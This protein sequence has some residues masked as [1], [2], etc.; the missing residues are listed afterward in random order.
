MHP[1]DVSSVCP[2]MVQRSDILAF[3]AATGTYL[4]IVIAQLLVHWLLTSIKMPLIGNLEDPCES[5]LCAFPVAVHVPAF[6]FWQQAAIYDAIVCMFS[7]W[8]HAAVKR[9]SHQGWC[10]D[11]LYFANISLC[12]FDEAATGYHL[13]GKFLEPHSDDS[14]DRLAGNLQKQ[15]AGSIQRSFSSQMLFVG[16]D[17]FDSYSVCKAQARMHRNAN[18]GLRPKCNN[19]ARSLASPLKQFLEE[20]TA[21]RFC[22]NVHVHVLMKELQGGMSTLSSASLLSRDD[23]VDAECLLLAPGI[24]SATARWMATLSLCVLCVQLLTPSS[25]QTWTRDVSIRQQADS[26]GKHLVRACDA[27]KRWT[28]TL[29][30]GQELRLVAFEVMFMGAIDL[31]LKNIV[32]SACITWV[33]VM[34]MAFARRVLGCQNIAHCTTIDKCFLT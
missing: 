26:S 11:Q 27:H 17:M 30:Y 21:V 13:D 14:L 19:T 15:R 6:H 8:S 22:G 12:I 9:Y 18:R 28:S 20:D 16:Q 33:V 34:V 4:L 2:N 10:R 5:F 23:V 1:N 7:A 31:H 3:G 24:K 25:W 29:F 32:A